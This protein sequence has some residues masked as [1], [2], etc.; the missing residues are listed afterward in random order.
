M[1]LARAGPLAA[2]ADDARADARPDRG[3]DPGDCRRSARARERDEP[4]ARRSHGDS[5]TAHGRRG[6]GVAAD[7]EDRREGGDVAVGG[8][9][10]RGPARSP[11]RPRA[12]SAALAYSLADPDRR[13]RRARR[14]PR[15]SSPPHTA[16]ASRCR[17]RASSRSAG[18]PPERLDVR[19][20]ITMDEVEGKGHQIVHS[21]IVARGVRSRT[22]R[23]RRSPQAAEAP[24]PA[25]RSRRSC[26]A[27]GVEHRP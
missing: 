14:A 1:T 11:P 8:E 15:S 10:A 4:A 16:G 2:A 3:L 9:L 19:C 21:A 6:D 5:A 27:P 26:A 12:R 23:G 18:T 17:S 20:T 7:A 22:R 25:A 24:T 13:R